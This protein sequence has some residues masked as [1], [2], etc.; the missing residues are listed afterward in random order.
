[1]F[2]L[3]KHEQ[4][5]LEGFSVPGDIADYDDNNKKHD[6]VA[7]I[8]RFLCCFSPKAQYNLKQTNQIWVGL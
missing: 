6:C 2:M 1:M 3:L 4:L 5:L 8:L 7:R